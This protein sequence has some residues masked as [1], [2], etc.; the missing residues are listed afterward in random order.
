MNWEKKIIGLKDA[1][2]EKRVEL[3]DIGR[4]NVTARRVAAAILVFSILVHLAILFALPRHTISVVAPRQI[5]EAQR[6]RSRMREVK[7][8]LVPPAT[9]PFQAPPLQQQQF[10]QSTNA[11]ENKP[12]ETPFFSD[13]N[14]QAAQKMESK[15]KKGRI[16]QVENGENPEAT[17]LETGTGKQ[18]Q[19]KLTDIVNEIASEKDKDKS[20]SDKKQAKMVKGEERV[21]PRK[22]APAPPLPKAFESAKPKDTGKGYAEVARAGN[23]DRM[24]DKAPSDR[25]I[26]AV[27]RGNPL[28]RMETPDAVPDSGG[29]RPQPRPRL[30]LNG[31]MPSVIRKTYAGLS[32]PSG[33]IA[34][35]T[36][37]SEF[38]DYLSRVLEAIAMKWYALNNSAT[39]SVTDSN[40]FVKVEFDVTKDGQVT[41]LRVIESN[42]S[43]SA[44]WRCLDAIQS[45]A[46][47]YEW[48]KD[49]VVVLGDSQPVSIQFIYR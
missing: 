21:M 7:V 48:T 32:T 18:S 6:L 26:E 35:D 15:V 41:N 14:Q 24:P 46:P 47:Y 42:S 11:P 31:S 17:A 22:E 39:Q 44:Q 5:A 36:R 2:R 43:R 13:K 45:N 16:P 33:N 9:K 1:P 49:M 23:A 28:V 27:Q 3:I 29:V 30:M 12:D 37:L 38:G 19:P 25:E 34:F 20:A 10:V 4:E 40:T 8:H